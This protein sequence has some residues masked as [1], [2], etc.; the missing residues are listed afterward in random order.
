MFDGSTKS[1][2][3][4]INVLAENVKTPTNPKLINQVVTE[5]SETSERILTCIQDSL[6]RHNLTFN[7]VVLFISDAA[8][9]NIKLK[10][11]QKKFP[12]YNFIT[13]FMHLMHNCGMVI[14]NNCKYQI[15]LFHLS[16]TCC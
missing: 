1:V 5:K 13:C 10:K 7:N 14:G 15:S 6:S 3:H 12:N 4:Y 2:L 11:I 9:Y 16:K 8:S